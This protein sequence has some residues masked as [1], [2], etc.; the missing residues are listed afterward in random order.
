MVRREPEIDPPLYGAADQEV[1]QRRISYIESLRAEGGSEAARW[2]RPESHRE[3]WGLRGIELARFV[4]PGERVFEFGAGCSQ[5]AAALPRGCDYVGSDAT[6][7]A[8]EVV[9]FDLNAPI[10]P[11]I[12]EFDVALFSGV[13]EYVHDLPRLLAYL[14]RSFGSVVA[15]YAPRLTDSGSEIEARRYSGWFND[16]SKAEIEGL[17]AEAGFAIASSGEWKAQLLYRLERN[18]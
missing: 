7:L 13:L 14:F 8:P 9:V 2:A 11:P 15:S 5:V 16:Y 10:L 4:K 12:E 17:F 3:R 18:R 6:P 1:R